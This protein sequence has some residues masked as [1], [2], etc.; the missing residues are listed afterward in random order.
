M[1]KIIEITIKYQI[2]NI[3]VY[4]IKMIHIYWMMI[5]KKIKK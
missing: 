3:K 1:L 2:K 4:M 5:I